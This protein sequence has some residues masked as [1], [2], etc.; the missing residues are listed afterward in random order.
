MKYRKTVAIIG[1]HGL[2]AKYGG[3]ETLVT[4]LVDY[5]KNQYKYIIFNSK[6]TNK[7]KNI[8]KDIKI[9]KLPLSASGQMGVIY[10]FVSVCI[11]F[12]NSNT[13]LLLGS[14]GML[15]VAICKLFKKINVIVNLDGIETKRGSFTSIAK[16][17]LKLCY[18]L[19]YKFAD[20]IILDNGY[21]T[22]LTPD[23]AVNKSHIISYGAKIDKSLKITDELIKNHNFLG[24]DYF[25]AM[26]RSISDNNLYELC[27]FFS[28][29]DKRIVLVSI[30]DKSSYGK[31]I[32]SKFS[33]FDNIH[34][35]NGLFD[36]PLLD[37]IRRK[38]KGYI[39]THS[40]CGTAPSLVEAACSDIPI[41]SIDVP[42]NRYTLNNDCAYFKNF[43]E[44]S[45]FTNLSRE[46]LQKYK[47]NS[48]MALRYSWEKIVNDYENLF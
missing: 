27:D 7:P 20:K 13:F 28:K 46:A 47:P 14:Q 33:N 25:F 31:N 11:A 34:L 1:T 35:I 30:L 3:F 10:D 39:H 38:C 9:I 43:S 48:D 16:I 8:P 6:F 4:N 29:T 15:L 18:Q 40:L 2:Y 19:S 17:Y 41:I 22:E 42:Q 12:F 36:K 45:N 24:D 32:L 5:K 37:L 44:L 26:G 21:F 23:L